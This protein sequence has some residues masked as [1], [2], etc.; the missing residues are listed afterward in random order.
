[1]VYFKGRVKTVCYNVDIGLYINYIQKKGGFFMNVLSKVIVSVIAL[2]LMGCGGASSDS[3]GV[4]VFYHG[5]TE[6]AVLTDVNYLRFVRAV[7]LIENLDLADLPLEEDDGTEGIHNKSHINEKS[8]LGYSTTTYDHYQFTRYASVTGKVRVDVDSVKIGGTMATVEMRTTFDLLIETPNDLLTY[9]TS[10]EVTVLTDGSE[11]EIL[12]MLITDYYLYD[13]TN[14]E[15]IALT[16]FS[17]QDRSVKLYV[18]SEGYVDVSSSPGRYRLDGGDHT[19]LELRFVPEKAIY[20]TRYKDPED[21]LESEEMIPYQAEVYT[22]EKGQGTIESVLNGVQKPTRYF[23]QYGLSEFEPP[24]LYGYIDGEANLIEYNFGIWHTNYRF[25]NKDTS[26]IRIKKMEWRVNGK[27]VKTPIPQELPYGY[28]GEYDT[29][30]F[31]MTVSTGDMDYVFIQNVDDSNYNVSSGEYDHPEDTFDIDYRTESLE[32]DLDILAHEYF[33]DKD[34][35]ASVFSWKV[36]NEVG[37]PSYGDYQII[38]ATKYQRIPTVK[39]TSY[40]VMFDPLYLK[41]YTKTEFKI[42]RFNLVLSKGTSGIQGLSREDVIDSI[43]EVNVSSDD[44]YIYVKHVVPVDADRNGLDD[45]V[46]TYETEEGSFLAVDHQE[47]PRVFAHERL[48]IGGEMH[49]GDFDGDGTQEV[50]MIGSTENGSELVSLE[51]GNVHRVK[52]LSLSDDMNIKAVADV[53]GDGKDDLIVSDLEEDKLYLYENIDDLNQ[54]VLIGSPVCRKV[55]KVTDLDGDGLQDIVCSP[56]YRDEQEE[57]DETT[58]FSVTLL[59]R[60]FMQNED[61]TFTSH[62]QE[63]VLLKDGTL[64]EQVW[65]RGHAAVW[66][67]EGVFSVEIGDESGENLYTFELTEDTMTLIGKTMLNGNYINNFFPPTDINGDGKK[68]LLNINSGPQD[69]SV[70]LQ[71]ED[72]SFDSNY[73]F[74][75]DAYNGL[76]SPWLNNACLRDIDHDGSPEIVVVSKENAFS[77]INLK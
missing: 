22:P 30:E 10:A 24:K 70:M 53:N 73:L 3:K 16:P 52:E 28:V 7:N 25:L 39:A 60:Y 43:N 29:I 64:E 46:Y 61:K 34:L 1:M 58:Y 65:M 74:P 63:Y 38:D 56:S 31:V 50:L 23:A 67:G 8:G 2:L 21:P 77:Y 47:S 32:F 49:V 69:L 33:E 9:K 68:D 55:L 26:N 71:K 40:G 75:L 6:K 35:D 44:D 36:G 17:M 76:A 48:S 41:L 51:K 18:G 42:V 37:G 14:E 19:R 62:T 27:S 66:V 15:E 72:G 57:R 13:K 45:I 5:A 11:S 20:E 4:S 59:M 12:E 54:T